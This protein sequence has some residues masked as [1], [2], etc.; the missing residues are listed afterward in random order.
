MSN[1]AS[2]N[3]PPP[4]PALRSAIEAGYDVFGRYR[5]QIPLNICRC[6]VCVDKDNE[7]RLSRTPLRQIPATLMGQYTASA[8][9]YDPALDGE[10]FRHFLPRYFELIAHGTPPDC[11]GDVAYC[12]SRLSL[13]DFRQA[14]PAGEMAVIDRFFDAILLHVLADS[15]VAIWPAGPLPEV[16]ASD[17]FIMV[18][19]AGGDVDRSIALL[20]Q[21]PDPAAAFHIARMLQNIRYDGDGSYFSTA[22]IPRDN[23]LAAALGRWLVRPQVLARLDAAFFATGDGDVQSVISGGI[24]MLHMLL[25]ST[26]AT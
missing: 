25:G 17:Y 12:L 26:A 16:N 18:Q 9:L 23:P 19:Q 6:A 21:A 2:P 15:R 1:P 13:T 3:W 7:D 8:H 14:W 11:F 24:D 20:E 22:L 10:T 5:R 4:T